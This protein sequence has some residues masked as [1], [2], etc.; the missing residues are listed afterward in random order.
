[1]KRF[2]TILVFAAIVFGANAQEKKGGHN[3][4]V[5]DSEHIAY[6][7]SE[8]EL[9]VEEAQVFWP[10]YNQFAQE[11]RQMFKEYKV[12][13]GALK[14]A[15]KEGDEAAI[16]SALKDVLDQK[17][18]QKDVFAEHAAEIQ[19]VVGP[20]KAAKFYV[21]EENFRSRQMHRLGQGK[22]RGNGPAHPD[23]QAGGKD[24]GKRHGKKV[25]DNK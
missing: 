8:M 25:E 11:Q 10:V 14:K 7:T 4:S 3:R 20:V 16:S 22:G 19:A 21:A 13:F 2:L 9:T 1:M 5:F 23:G 24:F 18:K 6:L 17:T 12:K 15:L